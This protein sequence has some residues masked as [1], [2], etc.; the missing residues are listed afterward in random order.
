MAMIEDKSF[1]Y[2]LWLKADERFKTNSDIAGVRIGNGEFWVNVY[3]GMGDGVTHVAVFY[4]DNNG[5]AW[6]DF[7]KM[8][9]QG[10]MLEHDT[11][12]GSFNIYTSDVAPGDGIKT[13]L[14]GHWSIF[15]ADGFVY[16]VEV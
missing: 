5:Q 11:I 7:D 8:R 6:F 12:H 1:L 9:Q 16:F 4:K 15:S 14:K 3:N 2:K 10:I 13:T